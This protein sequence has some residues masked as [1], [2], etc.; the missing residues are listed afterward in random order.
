M[1]EYVSLHPLVM[2]ILDF[3]SAAASIAKSI[4]DKW[5]YKLATVRTDDQQNGHVGS[6]R[7]F[8]SRA[9]V[10]ASLWM[11][12]WIYWL[13]WWDIIRPAAWRWPRLDLPAQGYKAR[14]LRLKMAKQ[15]FLHIQCGIKRLKRDEVME[16]GWKAFDVSFRILKCLKDST[17]SQSKLI[18]SGVHELCDG[19]PSKTL[20]KVKTTN[21]N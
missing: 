2:T 8:F 10:S 12:N 18:G 17:E 5:L 19:M 7:T 9:Q 14:G 20:H 16:K 21:V 1:F 4:L 6:C 3:S 13:W 15:N 11:T